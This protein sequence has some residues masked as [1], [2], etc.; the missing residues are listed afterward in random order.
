MKGL[1]LGLLLAAGSVATTALG[2]LLNLP[3]LLPVLG[4]AVPYGVFFTRVRAGRYGNAW[5]WVILWAVFQSVAVGTA[6]TLFPERGST[7]VLRG[8]EYAQ[9]MLHWVETGEGPEGSPRLYLPIHLRHYLGF[10]VLSLLTLGSA[11]LVLGTLLLNYMNYYV[12]ELVQAAADPWTAALFGWPLWAALR[13]LG[14]VASGVAMAAW[15]FTILRK[16]RGGS[17]LPSPRRVFLAGLGLVVADAVLK[18]LLAPWW[19]R[20]LFRAVEGG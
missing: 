19:Q 9:E 10:L 6:V 20:V 14:F 16:V 7:V 3:W 17:R 4:A 5:A 13:V 12:A 1:R 18:A 11:G 2:F 15:G 8:P